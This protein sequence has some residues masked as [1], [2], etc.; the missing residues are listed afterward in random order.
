MKNDQVHLKA[1]I[2]ALNYLSKKTTERSKKAVLV[3][4]FSV[5]VLILVAVTAE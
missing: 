3:T 4:F 2:E 5:L 1:Q